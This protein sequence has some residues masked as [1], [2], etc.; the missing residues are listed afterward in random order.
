M[1]YRLALLMLAL[2]PAQ[3]A[4]AMLWLRHELR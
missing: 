1:Q 4:R 2:I 3:P